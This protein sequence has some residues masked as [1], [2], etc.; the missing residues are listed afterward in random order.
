[1]RTGAWQLRK[2][3]GAGRAC[4]Q[5]EERGRTGRVWPRDKLGLSASE[6]HPGLRAVALRMHT[7]PQHC[8]RSQ[9]MNHDPQA[10]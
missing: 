4:V 5:L 2:A 7:A 10:V 3:K 1:M 6:A 9:Q 8:P